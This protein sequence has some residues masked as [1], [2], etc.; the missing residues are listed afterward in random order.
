[1]IEQRLLAGATG[2]DE[3]DGLRDRVV[4]GRA[5]LGRR[6]V[7]GA[8]QELAVARPALEKLGLVAEPHQ[9]YFILR[10]QQVAEE[11]L[12]GLARRLHPLAFHALAGVEHD[13][14]AHR[15][16]L[17]AELHDGL[18]PAVLE[19]LEVLAPQARHEVA[20]RPRHRRVHADDVHPALEG[21]ARPPGLLRGKRLGQAEECGEDESQ[22][23]RAGR[24]RADHDSRG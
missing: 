19:D 15:H 4:E 24:G 18:R 13:P 8:V 16:P 21:R 6:P 5:P 20:V 17:G 12:E 3:R 10:A 11:A 1:M 9:E 14:Q 2:L 22:G 23:D 7:E